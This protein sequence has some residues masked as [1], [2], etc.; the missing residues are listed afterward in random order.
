MVSHYES[1]LNTLLFMANSIILEPR[2][3]ISKQVLFLLE[4]IVFY[5]SCALLVTNPTVNFKNVTEKFA[6][7]SKAWKT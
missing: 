1:K 5:V 4:N 7:R 3:H 2:Y 6:K